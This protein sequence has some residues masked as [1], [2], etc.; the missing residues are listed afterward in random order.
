MANKTL[1][2][3]VTNKFNEVSALVEKKSGNKNPDYYKTQ[4]EQK[5]W[6]VILGL[7]TKGEDDNITL[8]LLEELLTPAK[9]KRPP[10]EVQEGDTVLELT[11]KYIDRT[12]GDIQKA[13]EAQGFKL[14]GINVVKA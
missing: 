4:K 2:T 5:L 13:I 8:S 9:K 7:L 14:D 6:A 12:M 3:N 1:V 11:Y 10:I